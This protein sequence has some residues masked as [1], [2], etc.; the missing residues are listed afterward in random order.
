MPQCGDYV[1]KR[2]NQGVCW[3]IRWHIKNGHRI[4]T[5][6][7]LILAR[8]ARTGHD[9]GEANQFLRNLQNTLDHVTV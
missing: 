8:M 6:A 2:V 3:H 1:A 7:I 5:R 4:T 9:V